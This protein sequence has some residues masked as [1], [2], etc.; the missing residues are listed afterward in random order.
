MKEKEFVKWTKNR[1]IGQFKF[2]LGWC[3]YVIILISVVIS[4]LNAIRHKFTFDVGNIVMLIIMSSAVGVFSGTMVWKNNETKY[5]DYLK[6]QN[7]N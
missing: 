1:R 5:N 6:K 3:L 7:K 4:V 2:T